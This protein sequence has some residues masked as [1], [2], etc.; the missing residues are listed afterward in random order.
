VPSQGRKE[1]PHPGYRASAKPVSDESET[2]L[3]SETDMGS[4]N[5]ATDAIGGEGLERKLKQLKTHRVEINHDIAAIE[6]TLG[7][8]GEESS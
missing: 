2:D 8:M 5:V 1:P 7:I 6:R 3:E 4:S